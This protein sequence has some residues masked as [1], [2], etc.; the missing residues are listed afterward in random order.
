MAA[1]HFTDEDRDEQGFVKVPAP[2]EPRSLADL[3]PK[4]E[5]IRKDAQRITRQKFTRGEMAA[6][7]A[8]ALMAAF[9]LLYAWSTPTA[10]QAP[11]QL[12]TQPTAQI[13]PT[14]VPATPVPTV[15]PVAMLPAFAA[16]NGVQL[17]TIEVT[18]TIVPVAHFGSDWIQADV[19]GS[20]RIWLRA[21]DWPAL[22]VVGPD[23]APKPAPVVADVPVWQPPIAVELPSAE[24][25]QQALT[26]PAQP[27]VTKPAD[28]RAARHAAAVARAREAHDSGHGSK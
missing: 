21:S 25:I 10:P 3:L 6:L 16:P 15:P 12:R 27:N 5:S 19:S 18:R 23:L 22:A 14:P 7:A 17:G 20:G 9:V 2:A 13:M 24:D 26:I 4:P 11:V 8:V 1:I 28:D